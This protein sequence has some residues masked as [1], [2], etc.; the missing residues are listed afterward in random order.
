MD[1]VKPGLRCLTHSQNLPLVVRNVSFSLVSRNR[2][3]E[4]A[5][6]PKDFVRKVL[7]QKEQGRRT[8]PVM[9]SKR[10]PLVP[11]ER[12]PSAELRR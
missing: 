2:V 7:V 3:E 1:P 11:T 9:T 8:P 4:Y 10:Q 5:R 12:P 6:I